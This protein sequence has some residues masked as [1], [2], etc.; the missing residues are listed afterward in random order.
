MVWCVVAA[1]RLRV[2]SIPPAA[3]PFHGL[4]ASG[5]YADPRGYG[6]ACWLPWSRLVAS[7]CVSRLRLQ[8]AGCRP[9]E[10]AGQRAIRLARRPAGP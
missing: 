7:Y 10:T 5:Q 2:W 4:P 8:A 9:R 1:R 6:S 3:P